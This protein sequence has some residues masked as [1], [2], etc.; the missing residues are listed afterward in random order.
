MGYASYLEDIRER[1][2]QQIATLRA[3]QHDPAARAEQSNREAQSLLAACEQTL[4]QVDDLM[5][6]VSDPHFDLAYEITQL[7]KEKA[8]LQSEI[9]RL[10]EQ[11]TKLLDHVRRLEG[12]RTS[13]REQLKRLKS[14]LDTRNEEYESLLLENP[15]AAYDAYSS[16]AHMRDAKPGDSSPRNR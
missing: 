16:P 15:A 9:K 11:R 6:L 14:E 2:D 10:N 12:E 1:L 4:S 7:D 3:A 13:F 5:E 8:D